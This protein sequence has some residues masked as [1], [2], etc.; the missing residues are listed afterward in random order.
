MTRFL[1]RRALFFVLSIFGATLI[2]FTLSLFGPDPR[3]LYIP[4]GGFGLT[5]EQMDLQAKK[6]G[7]DKPAIVRYFNWV[8]KMLRGNFGDSLGQMKPVTE[9][10][11]D[12]WGATLQLAVGGWIVAILFGVPMGVLAAIKR[13]GPL[14][15][16]A[17]LFALFG[18]ALPTFWTG[19]MFIVVFSMWLD[20]L[21]A[22]TRPPYFSIKH[23]ILPCLT[24]GWFPAAGIM[25]LTRSAMLEILD[26]EYIKFARAKG[27]REWLVV[28]KHALKNSVIVPLTSALVLLAGFLSGALVV[29]IVFS[30]P[31]LGFMTFNRAVFDNDFP[32]LL[33]AVF[34]YVIIFMI[35]AVIADILYAMIDPRI[36]YQ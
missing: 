6:L 2:I 34:F 7:L 1:A 19:I 26:S 15:Y 24:L 30:W 23:F 8:G 31:G 13:G 18:Q 33:G 14:D 3:N 25:R 10:L 28:W 21:P 9:I 17:R 27:V 5:Q 22:G 4:Q 29:E 16:A 12:K 36:R 11:R 32:L 20:W 35:M